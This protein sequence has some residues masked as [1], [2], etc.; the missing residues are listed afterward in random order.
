[1]A[2][3]E[4]RERRDGT[5]AYRVR[6]RAKPGANPTVETFETADDAVAFASLVDRIGG[7]A[8]KLKR[9]AAL[10]ASRITLPEVLEAY[11]LSAPDISPATANEYRRILTRSGLERDFG[12]LPV[13]L[14]DKADIEKWVRHRAAEVSPKTLRNE[15]GLLSTILGHALSRG[16][17]PV[18]AAKGVRLPK[19][20][21]AELEILTDGEFLALHTAMTDRYKPLVWLLAATGMRWGEAT[22]L[23]WRDVHEKH[24]DVRQAW[25]HDEEGHKRILGMPKTRQGRRRIETTAAVIEALGERGSAGDFV[26]TNSRGKEI[27][28][29]TF[30]RS[31]WAPAVA[32]AGLDPAP[33]IHGLRHFAASYMLS[34]GADIFEVSRALGHRDIATTTGVYGHLVPSRTRPTAV[35]AARLDELRAR[36]VEA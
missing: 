9:S 21:R 26:F 13:E 3:I 1:M 14:I 29:H 23:Q 10:T 17:V 18:N 30:H 33:K 11:I 8:A 24:I 6:F 7:E 31:H 16:Q 20:D 35:H 28:Y 25:K 19:V 34:Q 4:T 5:T 32:R 36:R 2:T 27:V 15:H 22:A 12:I